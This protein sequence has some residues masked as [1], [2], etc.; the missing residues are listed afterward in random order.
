MEMLNDLCMKTGYT[1]AATNP[2]LIRVVAAK[3]R[4]AAPYIEG[5]MAE[6]LYRLVR[7]SRAIYH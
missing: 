7:L 5:D 3:D 1:L 6:V 4:P 2:G